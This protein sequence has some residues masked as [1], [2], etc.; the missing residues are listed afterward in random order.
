MTSSPKINQTQSQEKGFTLVELLI[1][2]TIGMFIMAGVLTALTSQNQSYVTQD[3]VVEMQ[4]NARVAID[5]LTR[6]IRTAGYDPNKLDAGITIA[7]L[8]NLSFT[9]EDVDTL[10][11]D[12]ETIM[13]S[14]FDAY[15]TAVPPAND[16][17]ADDLARRVTNA[18]GNS[19]GRQVVCENISQLEF[20]YLDGDGNITADLDEIRTIEVS[21]LAV[22]S[23][24]DTT[25]TNTTTY[26][27]AAGTVWGPYNDNFRRRLIITTISCRNL[28]L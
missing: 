24:P 3:E 9:R 25:F 12:L 6:D 5:L 17:I 1:A 10:A 16:G 23:K 28:G 26:I 7:G 13:Y 11:A 19:A 27:S 8:N 21:L 22:V 14:L 2:I 15:A 20:R 18:G 4:Q